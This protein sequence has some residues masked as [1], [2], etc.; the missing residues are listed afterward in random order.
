[1]CFFYIYIKNT[2]N[3]LRH[4]NQNNKNIN[5][6]MLKKKD[7]VFIEQHIDKS[8]NNKTITNMDALGCVFEDN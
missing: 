3:I 6:D 4:T 8:S 2:V 5:N 7:I 1:M